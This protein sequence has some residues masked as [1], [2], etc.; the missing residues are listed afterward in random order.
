[1]AS[2]KS[3]QDSITLQYLTLPYRTLPTLTPLPP[4]S[5]IV[6]QST[7]KHPTLSPTSSSTT[8]IIN[9]HHHINHPHNPSTTVLTVLVLVLV[10]TATTVYPSIIHN[11]HHTPARIITTPGNNQRI[12]W[13][14]CDAMQCDAR[15]P[16]AWMI[17]MDGHEMG[18]GCG[19]GCG[20]GPVQVAR[21]SRSTP[22]TMPWT[23]KKECLHSIIYH[24][25]SLM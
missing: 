1:M 7:I 25:P 13:D 19:C 18:C 20:R 6:H 4:K 10:R 5:F 23:T 24:P 9:H 17:W 8:P 12:V 21:H 11:H 14:R 2:T 16:E 3:V 22:L 15:W